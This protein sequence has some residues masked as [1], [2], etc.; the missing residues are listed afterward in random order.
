MRKLPVFILFILFMGNLHSNPAFGAVKTGSSC[1][2]VGITTIKSGKKYTCIKNN[3]KLVWDKGVEIPQPNNREQSTQTSNS[4]P[5]QNSNGP[6]FVPWSVNFDTEV[7]T[8]TAIRNTSDYFGKVTP[9]HSY[10]IIADPAV[11]DSDLDWITKMLDYSDGAFSNIPREKVKVFI[12]NTND[13]AL[14]TLKKENLWIG[15]PRDPFPCSKGFG[16]TYCAQDNLILLVYVAANT[17]VFRWGYGPLSTPAHEMFHTVQTSLSYSMYGM[18]SL[19]PKYIPRWL[20]EGSANYFGYYV[21]DTLGFEKYEVARLGQISNN[22]AYKVVLPLIEYNK[23]DSDPYGIGQAAT[24][25]L[26]ASI[27]FNNFLNIWKFTK[28]EQNFEKG[29]KKAT[30]IELSEF[31]TKFE[32]ARSSLKI[33]LY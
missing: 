3:K 2:K 22:P 14:N 21:S 26:I 31:Y 15:D 9:R 11:R 27:G 19:S 17:R 8:K 29:F 20:M 28:S 24:E 7:M 16:D 30:G 25:Y 33:G 1:A 18:D 32:A 13:W 6:A 12:G 4:T 10:E 23:F 5:A